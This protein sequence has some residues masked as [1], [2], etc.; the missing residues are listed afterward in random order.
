MQVY[1]VNTHSGPSLAYQ[2][3]WNKND[4]IS[5]GS[6]PEMSRERPESSMPA[7]VKEN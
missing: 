4:Q 1:T 2:N 7:S 6:R 3:G 5:G